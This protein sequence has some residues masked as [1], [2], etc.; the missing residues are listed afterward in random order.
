MSGS[1]TSG[2]ARGLRMALVLVLAL[3]V[4]QSLLGGAVAALGRPDAPAG[5]KLP[6]L[7]LQPSQRRAPEISAS[8]HYQP[9]PQQQLAFLWQ[10][11]DFFWSRQEWANALDRIQKITA[12]DPNYRN[13]QERK[14]FAHVGY[15]YDLLTDGNCPAARDQFDLALSMRP[16]GPEA[17][18]GRNLVAQ[19]CPTPA[20]T[21]TGSVAPTATPTPTP[22]AGPTP[23]CFRV[24]TSISYTVKAGDTLFR[25]SRCFSVTVQSIMQANALMNDDIRPGQV[26]TIPGKGITPPGPTI[27]IVQPGE[28]LYSIAQRYGTTVWA[29]MW[30][31]KLSSPYARAYQ[32][33]FIPTVIQP[34]P[35][36]HIVQAGQTLPMLSDLYRRPIELIMLAN[37]LRTY[38]LRQFQRVI[39]P[40]AGWTGWPPMSVWTQ[41]GPAPTPETRPRTHIVAKGE[42]LYGISRRYGVSVAQL[43]KANGLYGTTIY[44]G[45]VL[46]IPHTPPRR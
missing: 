19:Y 26:I 11:L 35:I 22:T 36:I 10:E 4:A 28:T 33:L 9:D 14:Y 5:P 17:L 6:P 7:A 29:L 18:S 46:R 15:G 31:N 3:A 39:I 41:A 24:T 27:H 12:I 32:G 45:M 44:V 30:V 16:T 25:L 37:D 1:A 20:P 34:G 43:Q 38:E 8:L 21:A 42:T 13:V 23:E 2:G 40:P